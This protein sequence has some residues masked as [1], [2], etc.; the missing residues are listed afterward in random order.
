MEQIDSRSNQKVV[1]WSESKLCKINRNLVVPDLEIKYFLAHPLSQT[2]ILVFKEVHTE[3][4]GQ[5][6]AD[7]IYICRR[8]NIDQWKEDNELDVSKDE[9]Y[10]GC[11]ICC[12]SHI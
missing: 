5:A 7:F 11:L 6:H 2:L 8:R 9:P 4:F 10:N 12:L 3:V 1:L